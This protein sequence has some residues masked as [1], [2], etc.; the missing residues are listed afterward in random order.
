MWM[1]KNVRWF[2]SGVCTNIANRR[3][4]LLLWVRLCSQSYG[5][6]CRVVSN[7]FYMYIYHFCHM[8]WPQIWELLCLQ[9]GVWMK[10]MWIVDY[11][12][13]FS[14]Q[15]RILIYALFY[16]TKRPCLFYIQI[17][18]LMKMF[19]KE[20]TDRGRETTRQVIAMTSQWT[21]EVQ[22]FTKT[23]L[24]D[25]VIVIASPMEASF[26]AGVKQVSINKTSLRWSSPTHP[27]KQTSH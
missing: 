8:F 26:A 9:L 20:M 25:P 22:L 11:L 5:Y 23:H 19:D 24:N 14:Q 4:H 13:H 7:Y 2:Y 12:T 3:D 27:G 1:K 16:Y 21:T 17:E 18:E 15:L 10:T 6:K